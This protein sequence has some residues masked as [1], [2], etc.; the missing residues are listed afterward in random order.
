MKGPGFYRTC[1]IVFAAILCVAVHFTQA[2]AWGWAT[3]AYIAFHLAKKNRPDAAYGAVAPD[4]FNNAFDNPCLSGTMQDRMHK[5]FMPAWTAAVASKN[6]RLRAGAFGFVSHNEIWGEDVTAHNSSL[7]FGEGEGYVTAK[8]KQLRAILQQVPEFQSLALPDDVALDISHELVEDGIDILVAKLNPDAGMNNI[9]FRL[10]KIAWHRNKK[11]PAL[12]ADSYAPALASCAGISVEQARA[13]I[14][15]AEKQF[16]ADLMYHG[17]M[18]CGS[19]TEA[20]RTLS[21]QVAARAGSYLAANGITLPAG[22]DLAP[23]AR[24]GITSAMDLCKDDFEAE[25]N[26]TIASV[27]AKLAANGVTY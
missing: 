1:F 19:R 7:T 15:S 3:H 21:E 27:G 11:F 13:V 25:I 5:E 8:A 16:R 23:L 22:T 14:I 17:A 4:I 12:L 24:F 9:G 18:L 10:Y 26:A 2:L 6:A 20:V